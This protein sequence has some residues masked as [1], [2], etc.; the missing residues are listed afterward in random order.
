MRISALTREITDKHSLYAEVLRIAEESAAGA[1]QHLP[2]FLVTVPEISS[3]ETLAVDAI[4]RQMVIEDFYRDHVAVRAHHIPGALSV[5]RKWQENASSA[6]LISIVIPTLGGGRLIQ[7]CVN[8][9]RQHTKYPNFEV[10]VVQNGPRAEPEL[11]QESLDDPR[12]RVIRYDPPV[13]GTPFNWSAINN[14]AVREHAKGEYLCFV[15]DDIANGSEDW[16]DN[17][18]GHA[19]RDDVGAV[20]ARLIHPAGIIQ[21]VGVIAHKGIAGHLYKGGQNGNPGNGWLAALTHEMNA[22]TAA[23][24]MVSR[25]KFDLVDGFD[26]ENFPLNYSDTDFCMKLRK[27]GLRN[28]VEMTAELLH[29]EGT[30]RSNP[31]DQEGMVRRLQSDNARFA[32]KWPDPDPYWHPDLALGLA[33]GGMAIP[34]LDRTQLNWPPRPAAPDAERVLLINDMAG[35]AGRA[36]ECVRKGAVPL[37]ADVSGLVLRLI[38]PI[39]ANV[40]GW[41]VRNAADL[42]TDLKHLGITKI[43]L[44]SLVGAGGAAAPVE[45]LRCLAATGIPVEADPIDPALLTPW[46]SDKGVL[47]VFGAIGAN[48]WRAAYENLFGRADETAEAAD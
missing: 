28:V 33:Q 46:A 9:I 40:G 11:N 42:A 30:S 4:G 29:P 41:D 10:L 19:V 13:A 7:P 44:R 12:V 2:L 22:V 37:G 15:N 17:M 35:H 6:P 31:A 8:T 45:V 21:H 23:C 43:V 48:D 14:W 38:A 1:I 34:G 3:P 39:P 27:Q 5:I 47:P 20:G 24:M 26:E 32:A 36:L 16:L 25:A 18:L